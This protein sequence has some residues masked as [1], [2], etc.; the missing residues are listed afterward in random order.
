MKPSSIIGACL[1]A[2]ILVE[3]TVSSAENSPFGAV[4]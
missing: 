2:L 3:S 4:I 1:S